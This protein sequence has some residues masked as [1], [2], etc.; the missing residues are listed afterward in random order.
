MA[1]MLRKV[2]VASVLYVMSYSVVYCDVAENKTEKQPSYIVVCCLC[3][4]Q[5]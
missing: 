3:H 2:S 1:S 4:M 5:C